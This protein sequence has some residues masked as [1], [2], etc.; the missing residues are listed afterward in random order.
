MSQTETMSTEA[1]TRRLA[2][3]AAVITGAGSGI[4]RATAERYVHEGARV[5]VADISADHA[6]DT[7][8]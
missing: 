7:C 4:G 1:T 2:G 3:K 6:R 8:H 5:L